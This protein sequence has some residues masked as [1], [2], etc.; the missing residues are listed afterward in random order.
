MASESFAPSEWLRNHSFRRRAN[1]RNVKLLLHPFQMRVPKQGA[2]TLVLRGLPSTAC[3]LFAFGIPNKKGE[4]GP[5][6]ALLI[7][8]VL[9]V[10]FA[11]HYI[12]CIKM[13]TS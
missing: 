6:N 9:Q 7:R 4:N 2:D 12:I 8:R 11:V 5:K 13:D 10:T 1:V 3:V